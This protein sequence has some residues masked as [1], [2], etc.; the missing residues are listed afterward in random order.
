MPDLDARACKVAGV[1]PTRLWGKM[2]NRGFPPVSEDALASADLIQA[3]H[4]KT[5]LWVSVFKSI[6]G[7][8]F[9]AKTTHGLDGWHLN[10][11]EGATPEQAVARAVAEYEAEE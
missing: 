6:V 10:E 9:I 8:V 3:F 2:G 4:R 7:E 1:E 5:G 11:A